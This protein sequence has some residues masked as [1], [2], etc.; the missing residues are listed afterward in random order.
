MGRVVPCLPHQT[1]PGGTTVPMEAPSVR[2]SV[3]PRPQ[4]GRAG[5]LAVMV[6]VCVCVCC[7]L[8]G[9]E[10]NFTL[11]SNEHPWVCYS[12]SEHRKTQ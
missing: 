12:T 6:G 5:W 4:P 3:H 7:S 1:Q 8:D 2:L 9:H 10:K 11:H